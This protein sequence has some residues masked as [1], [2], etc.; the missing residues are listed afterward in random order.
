MMQWRGISYAQLGGPV[1]T[2]TCRHD[3]NPWAKNGT[4]IFKGVVKLPFKMAHWKPRSRWIAPIALSVVGYID[5]LA[6]SRE[7]FLLVQHLVARKWALAYNYRFTK[8][9]KDRLTPSILASSKQ[10]NVSGLWKIAA[11]PLDQRRK[12]IRWE[13]REQ[14]RDDNKGDINQ[15]LTNGRC[16]WESKRRKKRQGYP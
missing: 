8:Q 3:S 9:T 13:M 10:K 11:N 4:G 7:L 6:E 16:W 1:G 14:S 15:H 5:Y 12:N 2:I